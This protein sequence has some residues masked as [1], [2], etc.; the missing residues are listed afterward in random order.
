MMTDKIEP[1]PFC[2]SECYAWSQRYFDNRPKYYGCV[3]CTSCDYSSGASSL[4][5]EP[6]SE[7]E[8]KQQ[9]ITAHNRVAYA[10]QENP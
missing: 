4:D 3:E 8:A 10:V 6:T 2:G 5:E 9:A 7:A 1:C